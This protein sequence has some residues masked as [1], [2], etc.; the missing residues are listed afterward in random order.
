MALTLWPELG[1]WAPSLLTTMSSTTPSLFLDQSQLRGKPWYLLG[2]QP[3]LLFQDPA[4]LCQSPGQFNEHHAA[5][6]ILKKR[7]K[8]KKVKEKNLK[9]T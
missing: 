8:K 4:H 2:F 7:K 6:L 1:P 5:T 9:K 3:K